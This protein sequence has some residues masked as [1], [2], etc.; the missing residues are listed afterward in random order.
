MVNNVEREIILQRTSPENQLQSTR[1]DR[2]D[3]A[4]VSQGE[5]VGE[6]FIPN[7]EEVVPRENSCNTGGAKPEGC[8]PPHFL[9]TPREYTRVEADSTHALAQTLGEVRE[10]RDE[11]LSGDER[12]RAG[13]V[14]SQITLILQRIQHD[15]PSGR[16]NFTSL[17]CAAGLAERDEVEVDL[18]G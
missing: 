1:P 13:L 14:L 3:C 11:L 18:C 5:S 4:A 15:V 9:G 6:G 2:P 7:A 10:L 17:L 12:S 16:E 8:A